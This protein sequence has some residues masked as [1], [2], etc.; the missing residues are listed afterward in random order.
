MP[1]AAARLGSLVNILRRQLGKVADEALIEVAQLIAAASGFQF[2]EDR[3]FNPC[4]FGKRHWFV[5]SQASR[6]QIGMA[7]YGPNADKMRTIHCSGRAANLATHWSSKEHRRSAGKV[8]LLVLSLAF[9]VSFSVIADAGIN[10]TTGESLPY[11]F[12]LFPPL[13]YHLKE[14]YL[15]KRENYSAAIE[16]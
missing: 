15:G 4:G 7:R 14:Y 1:A 11:V 10:L 2:Q 6:G 13:K 9:A 8:Q 3:E 5:G 16:T 12:L